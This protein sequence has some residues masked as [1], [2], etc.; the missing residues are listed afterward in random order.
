MKSSYCISKLFEDLKSAVTNVLKTFVSGCYSIFFPLMCVFKKDISW[1][2]SAALLRKH[3]FVHIVTILVYFLANRWQCGRDR[4]RSAAK[5]CVK[6]PSSHRPLTA[7]LVEL[8]SSNHTAQ[9]RFSVCC[10]YH[11]G[12]AHAMANFRLFFPI[13]YI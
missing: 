1:E 9:G 4:R 5:I 12:A 11:T 13:C 10:F 8:P 6:F 7:L 3:C 2:A